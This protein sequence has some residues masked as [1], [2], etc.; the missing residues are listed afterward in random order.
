MKPLDWPVVLNQ[1][2]LLESLESSLADVVSE[3]PRHT[4]LLKSQRINQRLV[5]TYLD[6]YESKYHQ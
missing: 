3:V 4:L 2:R 6:R 1:L 5:K